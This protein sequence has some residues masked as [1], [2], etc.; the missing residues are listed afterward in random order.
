M[1]KHI[2]VAIR[3][4]LHVTLAFLQPEVQRGLNDQLV[5]GT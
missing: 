1:H 4:V 5:V 3:V 2:E